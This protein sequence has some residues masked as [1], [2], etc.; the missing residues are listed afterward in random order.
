MAIDKVF[1]GSC[2]NLAYRRFAR[3]GRKSPKGVKW[4]RASRAL[5]VTRSGPVKAQAEA[6]GPDK[7]FIEAGFEWRFYRLLDVWR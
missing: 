6:E 3:R 7:I 1:I 4:R 5:V 2:T